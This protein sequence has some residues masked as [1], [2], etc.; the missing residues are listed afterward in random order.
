MYDIRLQLLPASLNLAIDFRLCLSVSD[1]LL[2]LLYPS[3]SFGFILVDKD[4]VCFLK[5]DSGFLLHCVSYLVLA[6]VDVF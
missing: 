4:C 3:L 1:D 6:S 5:F 2:L